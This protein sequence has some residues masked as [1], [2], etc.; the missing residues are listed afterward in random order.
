M[1]TAMI[2]PKKY[3]FDKNGLPLAFGKI[4]TYE[5]GTN[6]PKPTFTTEIGDVEN[7]N[8]VIL[9]AE[10]YASIY[11]L[12]S[13]NIIVDDADDANIWTEDPVSSVQAAEWVNCVTA[14]YI[15]T[16][17]FSIVG[18]FT[19][20]YEVGRKVRLDN[21]VVDFAY[22]TID[23][24]V[25]SGPNTIV[26]VTEPVVA[27]ALVGAC[28]SIVGENS[29]PSRETEIRN[30]SGAV[31][32]T[33]AE[34]T[35]ESFDVGQIVSIAGR[36][37]STDGGGASYVVAASQAVDGFGN[38]L[39]AS[40]NALL[41][42]D[43]PTAKNFG[44]VLDGVV[45]DT[46][47]LAALD[48]AHGD[49]LIEGGALSCTDITL[50]GNITFKSAKIRPASG[51]EVTIEGNVINS[52]DQHVFSLADNGSF[53][54][55]SSTPF[56]EVA[57][58]W[59]GALERLN[60]VFSAAQATVDFLESMY[61]AD[62]IPLQNTFNSALCRYPS[63]RW[64]QSGRVRV[65]IGGIN[66]KGRGKG[67]TQ[68]QLTTT[69]GG[70]EFAHADILDGQNIDN[71]GLTD[72]EILGTSQ[73]L[74]ASDVGLTAK[75]CKFFD[76][77]SIRFTNLSVH[78]DLIACEEP[79]GLSDLVF[80]HGNPSLVDTSSLRIL[81]LA[82][83]PGTPNAHIDP[84]T[85]VEYYKNSL[86]ALSDG[87][88]FRA[89]AGICK[90]H[91][92]IDGCDGFEMSSDTHILGATTQVIFNP[93]SSR[94]PIANVTLDGFFD[95]EPGTNRNIWVQNKTFVTDMGDFGVTVRCRKV[96]GADIENVLL[97][98]DDLDFF[99]YKV[100]RTDKG[101]GSYMINARRGRGTLTI[102]TR[103]VL[104]NGVPT[105]GIINL[106]ARNANGF[107]NL[108][109]IT[110]I[111][112]HNKTN[113]NLA[114]RHIHI[115]TDTTFNEPQIII[116]EL[117]YVSNNGLAQGVVDIDNTAAAL[118]FAPIQRN[119]TAITV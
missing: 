109:D 47:A 36:L 98:H 39:D 69:S 86:I 21:N 76:L 101:F 38:H 33:L 83:N 31:F 55:N 102:D 96:N 84:D 108:V 75:V 32:G 72:M 111:V 28:V 103:F 9:N 62:S 12:G 85:A 106:D 7:T 115:Q 25:L 51:Q 64:L 24:A 4:Y 88:E 13:Y 99:I 95:G 74:S 11:I 17:S 57:I 3:F 15:S 110:G 58:T 80:W 117:P 22:S 43:L 71:N 119:L 50:A 23:S 41:L 61:A 48:T 65:S 49:Y 89:S 68:V 73:V 5:A 27:V 114:A 67:A 91:I 30:L 63:G 78:A 82:V 19:S 8:P 105:L 94:V 87:C 60:D 46:A 42:L 2:M 6:N 44:C 66:I 18:D 77:N 16:T 26:T 70:F 79:V 54:G 1:I 40:G 81:S 104:S 107:F 29:A 53:I 113:V 59:F 97:E 118:A 93:I 37:T 14:A 90:Q 45:D 20:E 116:H 10:G 34:M 35:A 100:D 112:D 52:N 92:F 56:K